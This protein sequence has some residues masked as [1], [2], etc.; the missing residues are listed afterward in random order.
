MALR[1]LRY[2]GDELLRKK[3]KPVKD[4]TKNVEILIDDLYDTMSHYNGVGIAAPQVG[5]LKR[6]VIVDNEGEIYEMINP[7]ITETEGTQTS[8]EGCLSIP[9]MIG[10]V[11]R[12]EKLKVKYT[13]RRGNEKELAAEG[14][15][16]VIICHETDHLDGVL[17]K[18]VAMPDTFRENTPDEDEESAQAE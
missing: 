15:F 7:V 11:E 18:D 6:I 9:G 5:I 10:T 2:D 4:I 14:R 8:D 16:A 3:S 13:D 1:N 12:P 17:Y